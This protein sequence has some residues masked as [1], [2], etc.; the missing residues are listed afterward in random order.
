MQ[1]INRID[2]H[3]KENVPI[4]LVGTKADSDNERAVSKEEGEKK[5]KYYDIKF[6]EVSARDYDKVDECFAE[7]LYQAFRMKYDKHYK[8]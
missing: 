6:F 5:A 8:I 2:D 3:A 4:I 1:W 7:L